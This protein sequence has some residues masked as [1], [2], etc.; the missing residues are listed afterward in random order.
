MT[1]NEQ[2]FTKGIES[3]V[4]KEF[5][6]LSL[7]FIMIVFSFSLAFFLGREVA[8]SGQQ[9]KEPDLFKET[10]TKQPDNK[11]LSIH[12]LPEKIER[13]QRE[14]VNEYK[15]TLPTEQT[16]KPDESQDKKPQA[17]DKKQEVQN[18]KSDEMYGLLITVHDDKE[19]ATEKS[20][21]L[22]LRFPQ[23]QF[24]FKKS[25]STYKVYIGPFRTKSSAKDFLKKLQKNSEFSSI[26]LEKI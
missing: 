14:K 2:N 3:H 1:L 24:F 6:K 22:K 21:Q 7:V 10:K 5:Y 12:S 11:S 19:S 26:K 23:W 15:K 20:T 16:V 8:L 18:E 25:K 4:K 9:K 13:T 17:Q